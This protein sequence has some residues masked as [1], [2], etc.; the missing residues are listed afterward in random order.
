M[1]TDMSKTTK[2]KAAEKKKSRAGKILAIIIIAVIVLSASALFIY[3]DKLL[4]NPYFY[5]GIS[6]DGIDLEGMTVEKAIDEVR[7]KHQP[8]LDAIN[9]SLQF[10]ER[11]WQFN[12]EDIDA[13][14]N[15]ED[16]VKEAY[17]TGRNGKV[18][19]RI[20][21]IHE[22]RQVGVEFNTAL[23]YNVEKLRSRI[24]DIS[25]E[26]NL[27][28]VDATIKF[29]PN[30]VKFSFT[31]EASGRGM[32]VDKT[33]EDIKAKVDAGDYSPYKIP[34]EELKP[35]YTLQEVKTWTSKLSEFST[36][37]TG[38]AER[39]YNI[40]LSAK[41]FNGVCIAPGEVFSFN[42]TTGPRDAK[43]GYKDAPVIKSGK[44]LV[45]EPGGGNCQTSSTLYAAA[46]RADL[47]IAERYPHSWPSSYI[48]IGQDATVNYPTADF[49]IKNNKDSAVFL[50]SYASGDRLVVEVYGKA[51]D[52]YDKIDVQS[53][54]LSSTAAPAEKVVN[55]PNL[56]KGQTIVEYKSRPG[57]KVQSYRIY[58]KNG[59]VV[60][61]VKEAYSQY[62]VIKGKKVVGTKQVATSPAP[63]TN[64]EPQQ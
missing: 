42:E 6:V 38:S 21:K 20:K 39:V 5:E 57:Y 44:K 25:K 40:K 3:V 49:K 16:V 47:Q 60:K 54:V 37:L 48:D 15:V 14:I 23:T 61:K 27:A 58:Y 43:H 7:K 59:K 13:K 32:L 28:P 41:S 10:G 64:G 46:I 12:Y 52:E 18:I 22:V 9:I 50:R 26:I 33:M 56:P 8:E 17:Q 63:Q 19:D 11:I 62:P 35:K 53:T 55:D 36:K 30:T 34:V 29:N 2:Q 24:E 4:K 51:T 31:E 45:L 1:Q